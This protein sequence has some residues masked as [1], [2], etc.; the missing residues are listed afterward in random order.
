MHSR[1]Y[2]RIEQALEE[3]LM[4]TSKKI[5]HRVRPMRHPNTGLCLRQPQHVC[6]QQNVE[7]KPNVQ[8]M[9]DSK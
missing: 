4:Q 3:L 9:N 5:S 8:S 6:N 1:P 2:E 7:V